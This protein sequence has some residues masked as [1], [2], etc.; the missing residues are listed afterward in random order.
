MFRIT[1]QAD[2]GFVLLGQFAG[3]ESGEVLSAKELAQETGLPQPMVGKILKLLVGGGIL[4]SQRGA[5]GGYSLARPADQINLV[6]II[7][8]LEGPV[9]VTSCCDTVEAGNC[10][11]QHG[12]RVRVNWRR[13]GHRIREML[14]G[15]TL[16]DMVDD[17]APLGG[18]RG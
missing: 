4:V 12:C 17:A 3:P 9:A 7:E 15:L 11:I 1:K 18:L 6:Q 10:Q 16:A 2:Y 14:A 5:H 13:V 8:C